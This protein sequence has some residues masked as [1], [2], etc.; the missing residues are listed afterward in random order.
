MGCSG[1][2]GECWSLAIVTDTAQVLAKLL[3]ITTADRRIAEQPTS[4]KRRS[5]LSSGGES[6]LP[7]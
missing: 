6:S 3:V 5:M 7:W 4:K 1:C 2:A